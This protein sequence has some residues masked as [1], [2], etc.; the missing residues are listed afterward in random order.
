M[1]CGG[2]VISSTADAIAEVAAPRAHLVHPED[3]DGWRDA[4]E[5]VITDDEW[6]ESLREGAVEHALPFTW[7]RCAAE[8]LQVYRGACGKSMSEDVPAMAA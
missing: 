8:T 1:A 5:R 4:M 7:E 2:A 3:V 6:W